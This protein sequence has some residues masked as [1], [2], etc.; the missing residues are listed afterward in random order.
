[1]NPQKHISMPITK[2]RFDE[3]IMEPLL[4]MGYEILGTEVKEYVYIINGRYITFHDEKIWH[5]EFTYSM[6]NYDYDFFF[7][8]INR[9]SVDF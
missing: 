4:N 9:I 2:K 1:M 3:E 8:L 7:E 6:N 5:D